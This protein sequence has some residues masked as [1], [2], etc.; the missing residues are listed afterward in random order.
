MTERPGYCFVE[1]VYHDE[2]QR[3][4]GS[5]NDAVRLLLWPKAGC[6]MTIMVSKD[7]TCFCCDEETGH[8][9]AVY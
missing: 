1:S 2:R 8:L 7:A 4:S 6:L 5:L 9:A 3:L